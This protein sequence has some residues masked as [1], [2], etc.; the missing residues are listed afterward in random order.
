MFGRVRRDYLRKRGHLGIEGNLQLVHGNALL[1]DVPRISGV[2]E[3]HD[4]EESTVSARSWFT[5]RKRPLLAPFGVGTIDQALLSVLQT[6]HWF[7]RLFGL[8]NK[9]VVFD[10]VHAYD[11][12]TSTLLDHL[13]R[14]LSALDCTVIILSATLPRRRLSQL[15]EAYSGSEL[16][17]SPDYPRITLA[18][19]AERVSIS[20]GGG[21]ESKHVP[22][23]F[24]AEEPSK[25]A[26]LVRQRLSSGGCAAV[27][28]NTVDRAQTVYMALRQCMH[29]SECLLFHARTPF[30]W[31]KETEDTVLRKFGKPNENGDSPHRP[32]RA[33]VVAT[34]VIEQSL[35]LDFDWVLTD[36][37]PIDLILQRLGREHRHKRGPRPV[38]VNSPVL[39]ILSDDA[40]GGAPPRFEN[41][42]IYERHALLRSWLAVTRKTD[43]RL[44]DDI[45]LLVQWVYGNEQPSRLDANWTAALE[46]ARIAFQH[47]QAEHERKAKRILV[48]NPGYPEDIIAQFNKQ[49][50]EDDDP[51][52]HESVKAATRDGE[53][54]I[55]VVCL[56]LRGDNLFPACGTA[57]V[58]LASEPN[59]ALTKE[60]LGSSLSIQKR[61]LYHALLQQAPP[62]GWRRSPHLRFHRVLAFADGRTSVGPYLLSISRELGLVVA[63]EAS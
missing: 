28:C 59:A 55:Q 24:A 8:A 61:G 23:E 31:R 56:N 54:S 21:G 29:E 34:Q 14:W 3:D 1:S 62:G 52:G 10:E 44:P 18:G 27:V 17:E 9:V 15:V 49:L 39:T 30:A 48:P 13:V 43:I 26:N 25:V 57:E 38:A 19:R 47:E 51:S 11:T 41:A 37:A 5:A 36:M 6:R 53:P 35:D 50:G 7:V 32:H 2:S 46:D 20:A 16:T 33:V 45:D 12:Y 22:V 4:S 60:L 42:G 40:V 58:N 63:K